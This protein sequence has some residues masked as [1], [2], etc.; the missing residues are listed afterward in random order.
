MGKKDWD[1][2][3]PGVRDVVRKTGETAG[4]F[5][6]E[7][8][9]LSSLVES[10][11]GSAGTIV[12]DSVMRKGPQ[13]ASGVYANEMG[14]VAAALAAYFQDRGHMLAFMAARSGKSL[15]GAI[16]ATTE[17]VNGDLDMAADAQRTALTA[18]EGFEA[19]RVGPP[20][21]AFGP[22]KDGYRK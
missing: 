1:I 8:K 6:A 15:Q 17:Y 2:D 3:P 21:P 20:P 11:A 4:K 9:A 16:Q 7:G 13:T 18:P 22:L 19:P 10:A 14:P 12:A 5:E